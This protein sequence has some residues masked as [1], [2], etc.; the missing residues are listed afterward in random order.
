MEFEFARPEALL[1]LGLLA[2]FVLIDRRSRRARSSVRRLVL[3]AVRSIGFVLLVAA[4]AEPLVWTGTDTL[5]TV[6]LVDRSASVS[7][8]EQQRAIAWIEQAIQQRH[9]EDRAAVIS[10]AGDAAVEQGLSQT[11][12]PIALDAHLDQ[13]HTDIAAALRLAQ[14]VLPQGGSRRIVLL[15]DGNQNLEN[16]MDELPALRAAGIPI[17]VVPL[18]ASAGPEVA[19]RRLDVPSAIHKGERFTI[20]LTL[21]STVETS[22]R[23]RFLIDQRLDATQTFDL[24]V[25]DNSLLVSHDPLPPGEH[26]LSVVVE[27]G[28]DTLPENNVGYATFQVAG[29]PRILL[30]EGDPGDA[31]YLA[32]A[33]EAAGLTTDVESPSILGGDVASLRQYDAVGL[34]N[35][36]ATRIGPDGLIALRS[37]VQDFGGGLVVIGGDRSFGVG[38]YARTPLE[39]ALPVSMDVRGRQAR[40][41][42]V[43]ILVIDTSGSMS[44]GPPGATKIDLAREAA[45]G[46][47]NELADHDQVGIIAFDEQPRWIYPTAFLTDRPALQSAISRLEAG[48]GTEIFPALQLAYNDIVNRS[49][50]VKHILLMTDGLSPSG[51]YAGL[52]AKMRAQGITL[53][54]IAIGTDADVNLLQNL[55]DWGRGRFYDASNPLDVPRFVLTET[56]EVARAAVTEE[57]FIPTTVDQTPILAGI[58]RIPPL[59]GYVAT[60]PKPAAVVGLESPE[61]DP[62]LA[63]WQFGLGR[64]VAFTSDVTARWSASWVTW[65]AFS[66]FW[67]QVFKWT[68]PAPQSQNLQ[69][70]TTV[71]NGQ[72]HIVVDAV[73][74]DGQYINDATTTAKVADPTGG[75][76]TVE[77]EQVAPGQYAADV[78]ATAQGAY[79]VQVSQKTADQSTTATQTAGFTVPYSPEFGGLLTDTGFL[80]QLAGATGG[81]VLTRPA[82]SFDHNLRPADAARPVW[83]DLIALLIPVFILDVAIRRLRFAP[84][85]LAPILER[86]RGRWLG[87][88]G[89]ATQLAIRLAAVRRASRPAPRP[90][91]RLQTPPAARHPPAPVRHPSGSGS[92]VAAAGPPTTRLLAAK[93]R[94]A[95]P[96]RGGRR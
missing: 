19:V 1:L 12:G 43:L 17:D 45:L 47:V 77:L 37:Y 74:S 35:V 59:Y 20:N 21:S 50:K 52:T 88:T 72:A 86:V 6:F 3:L 75:V 2:I 85:D 39:E 73:G 4:L 44:E 23:V 64:A 42:V 96:P 28:R 5:S 34:V 49:A 65:D 13:S 82:E 16:A 51:D 83:P 63:Q 56:T 80:R 90:V 9:P 15:S 24:H 36:P 81:R 78:P 91:L 79:L 41:N 11:T 68:V 48:G 57:T 58:T 53:S 29:P 55:A 89:P 67:A 22:A 95:P 14:G 93:R 10:F 40:A 69:V 27:P 25:G 71:A 62:I 30:V 94:A 33:L 61:H 31:R 76:R 70:R 18:G 7:A 66:R 26:T 84:A 46:A 32:K 8:S 60:T 38:G 87:T 92:A 54:T